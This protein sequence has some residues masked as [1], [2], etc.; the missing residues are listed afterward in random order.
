MW[1]LLAAF[2]C[3]ALF[4]TA[5][6]G[7]SDEVLSDAVTA[8]DDASDAADD[9]GDSEDD[10][11]DD[12]GSAEADSGD[13]DDDAGGD[14]ESAI[15]ATD[16]TTADE[17]AEA[18]A[19]SGGGDGGAL[20]AINS[21]VAEGGQPK[22]GGTLTI[23]WASD[24]GSLD[25]L[26]SSSFNTHWRVGL[27]YQRLFA[28]KT[29]AEIGYAQFEYQPELA[30]SL[31]IADDG[32]TYTVALRDD[33]TWQDVDPVNGRAFVCDD[34]KATFE[35]MQERGFQASFL[36]AVTSME[37]PDDTTFIMSLAGPFA[38]LENYLGHHQMWILPQE[39]FDG[40]FDP[41]AIAIG[42]GPFKMTNRERDVVTEYE[43]NENFWQTDEFGTQLPYLDGVEWFVTG[44][45]EAR[46]ANLR[47][48]AVDMSA[49]ELSPEQ[50]ELIVEQAD[51]NQYFQYLHAAPFLMGLNMEREEFQNL[52]VRQAIS[53]AMDR[54]GM[55][56][57]IIGGGT[58]G[59]PVSP[60]LADFA[61]PEAD[62]RDYY[63]YDLEGAQALL[64]EAGYPDGFEVTL[65][66]TDA[67]GSRWTRMTE[68]IA[69][70]MRRLGLDV[71][72]ETL[73]YSTYFGS[74]W[75]DKEFDMQIGP[76]TPFVE[77]DEWLRGQYG[78]NGGRN[79]YNNS[80][81]A[82]DALLD[83]QLTLLD[84]AARQAKVI[85]IQEYIADNMLA[86]IPIWN[87]LTNTQLGP[88]V[89]NYWRHQT[90]GMTGS[91]TIWLDQ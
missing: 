71:T 60:T 79:W 13:G 58:Y 78:T 84:P 57:N 37:C 4:A 20:E 25:P 72:L 12:G 64:A 62:R 52:Q 31:D 11:G 85:E 50:K 59:S 2:S 47:A 73:D 19:S 82:L 66:Y 46:L 17:A 8:Q 45:T 76:Q 54:E 41:A 68:W 14:A 34:V 77:A 80:D 28:P 21:R 35:N 67:Y 36:D 32:L 55:A 53:M 40:S 42:T 23:D 10:S 24:I 1:R 87:Q 26:A 86:P 75:P 33:V 43:R 18:Q 74:R 83:E 22:S 7:G 70:D 48:G 81:P 9:S 63:S 15:S 89:R 88:D 27:V 38:P 56:E 3:I 29:G 30:T 6:G 65:I 5:C 90:Y 49:V 51:F 16:D 91:Q 44:D 69:E 61:L 39:A